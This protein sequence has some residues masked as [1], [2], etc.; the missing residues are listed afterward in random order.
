[1][2]A[3]RTILCLASYHKGH[4]FL[5]AAKAEG[6]TVLLLTSKSLETAEWPAEVDEK[7]YMPDVDKVWNRDDVIKGVSYVARTRQL[8][9]IVALDDFDVETAAALREHLRIPGM[10]ET[11]A[12]Y[13]RDKLAMRQRALE[14]GVPV[15]AFSPVVNHATAAEFMRTAPGPWLLKPRLSASALGIKKIAHAD[16]LWP[17]L[18]ALGDQQSYY[19]LETFVPGDVYH[20]DSLV[21]KKKVIFAIASRYGAPPLAVMHGGGIFSTVICKH[22]SAEERALIAANATVLK[23]MGHVRGVSHTEFIR[24]ADG[25]FYFLET[26]ARVGGANIMDLIECATGLNLWREWA[27]LELRGDAYRVPKHRKDYA[28]LLVSLARQE[29]PDVESF[30]EP[31]VKIRIKKRHHVGL[32]WSSPSY[33]RVLKLQAAYLARVQQEFHASAPPPERAT[34]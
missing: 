14:A 34:D 18:D 5:R 29:W 27:R 7:F 30:A 8:D 25:K 32:V 19:L 13:F 12:R 20:V 16:E 26:S 21:S 9:L 2:S 15:P 4:E 28:G 3:P 10:G 23:A 17:A 31:E 24:G 6:W 1:M 22:G 11:T 33:Q